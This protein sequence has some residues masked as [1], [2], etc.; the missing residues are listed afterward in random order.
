M[1]IPQITPICIAGPTGAGKSAAAALL[2]RELG[3]A[4]I[5]AD[6]RQLYA[7]FPIITA[8]PGAEELAQ[9]PH[10]LYGFLSC[11][12]K[13]S[14]GRYARLAEEKIAAVAAQGLVPILVGG[15]GLY[16]QALL[17]GIADIPP[18]P[19][20]IHATWQE[21]CLAKGSEPLHA[22]L[23][24]KDPAYAAKIH[25][26]DRQRIT[27]ALE[28]IDFTGKAFSWWHAE[29]TPTADRP[30]RPALLMAVGL[31][32]AELEPLLG[33][34]IELMLEA[35]AVAEAEKALLACPDRNTPGWSGIGCA[36]LG[37]FLAGEISLE[38]CKELWRRNTRAYAKRQL[39]WFRAKPGFSWYRPGQG[40]AML[41]TAR[42]RLTL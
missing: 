30:G 5:N 27:R 1:H 29:R 21:R 39:T 11:R 10:H 41:Q 37:R 15:T 36:E 26:H 20:E 35:G 3:G 31:P 42:D 23:R 19:E 28:V 8:Q 33:R 7:D 6:S 4:V 40:A 12:E 25:P 22:L 34:R 24:E 18:V 32:L 2:A 38:D 9:A 14:A 17:A 16:F 13:I